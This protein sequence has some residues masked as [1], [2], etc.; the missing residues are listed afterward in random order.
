MKKLAIAACA[1]VLGAG[2]TFASS[3]SVPWFVDNAPVA[4]K[5]PG[6][7]SGVTGL[8][9]LKNTTGAPIT[10]Q[11]TYFAQDGTNL[12]PNGA[13]AT[14]SIAADSSLAFR[15][16]ANDPDSVGGGQEGPQ[17]LAVPNRPT[18]DG[19]KNG[20]LVVQWPGD[21]TD[22]QGQVAYFQTTIDPSRGGYVTLTYAHL[23]PPGI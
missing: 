2:V 9:T 12:G 21:P 13:D 16:V 6:V 23:L 5:V 11:I 8:V 3:L 19:K 1:V 18:P 7:A 20:A 10:A 14:F 17:G 15:P 4:N 22:I